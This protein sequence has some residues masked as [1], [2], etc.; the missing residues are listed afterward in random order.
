MK[1]NPLHTR[2][3]NEENLENLAPTLFR[4]KESAAGNPF[5]VPEGY[6][7]SLYAS[8]MDQVSSL[9]DFENVQEKNPFRV[10]EGYFESLPVEIQQRIADRGIK[11]RTLAGWIMQVFTRP[12]AKYALAFA[13]LA[14]FIVFSTKYF[15]RTVK[16]NY[17]EE[18]LPDTEQLDIFYLQQLDESTLADVYAEE[19]SVASQAQDKSIENYLLDNDI[20]LNLITEHL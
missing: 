17:A 2:A 4:I 19:S 7:D 5:K 6:F 13:S 18:Q 11:E 20:D 14:L 8:V 3:G 15:T 1:K 9:P 16:V 12:A 10:P